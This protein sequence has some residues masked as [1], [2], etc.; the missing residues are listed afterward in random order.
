[1]ANGFLTQIIFI[2]LIKIYKF[3]NNKIRFYKVLIK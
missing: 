1:M 2:Y 3:D